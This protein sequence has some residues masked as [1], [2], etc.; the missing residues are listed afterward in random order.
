MESA[1]EGGNLAIKLPTTAFQPGSFCLQVQQPFAGLARAFPT[2]V[3]IPPG[4]LVPPHSK[5]AR[6]R[7]EM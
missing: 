6:R 3:E 1:F 5:P 4:P 7:A 2:S